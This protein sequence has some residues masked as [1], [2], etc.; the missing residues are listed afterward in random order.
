MLSCT[1]CRTKTSS[2]IDNLCS[3]CFWARA[4]KGDPKD[5]KEPML[6]QKMSAEGAK[7][8]FCAP[9]SA[10]KADDRKNPLWLLPTE[11]LEQVGLVLQHGAEKYSVSN[12]RKGMAWSRMFSAALR[13]I[14]ARLRGEVT[15][16]DSGLPHMAHASCCV[17]F[18]LTYELLDVGENDLGYENIVNRKSPE[19]RPQIV[20]LCGSTRFGEAFKKAMLSETLAGKIV[21]S[22]GCHDASDQQ[23]GIGQDS[24]VKQKLD[25]L[26]LRKI[27]MCDEVLVLNV[28][29]YVGK[30]VASEVNYAHMKAKPV[31]YLEP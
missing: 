31:Y 28:G 3:P 24:D 12:W 26:H 29:G 30:S 7:E 25:E 16:S 13:H 14:F 2:L 20:C 19:K 23:L 11:A 17:L 8:M 1:K 18:A 15:D 5:W 22:V 4:Q 27:D 10:I 9:D 21:L 6:G